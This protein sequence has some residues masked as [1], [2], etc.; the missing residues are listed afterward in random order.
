MQTESSVCPT[1]GR[2]LPAYRN[3][4]PT[5]D[6]LI[7]CPG[8]GVVLIE[9]KN[10]PAGWALPGGFVDYGEST[11]TAAIREALEETGLEVELT[12][13]LGVYSDPRR[14]PRGHTMS[15]VYTAQAKDI[16]RLAAGDDAG[17]ARIFAL[18]GLP[19]PLAFDHGV[20][21]GDFIR[22]FERLNGAREV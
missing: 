17:H 20:I 7:H 3:P 21:L 22:R 1:C 14:D 10:A 12:G 15:V 2:P 13:L 19:A 8:R 18:D 16:S 6:I 9:R 11:E 4:T 5:V